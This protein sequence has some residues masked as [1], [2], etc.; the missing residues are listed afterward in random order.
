MAADGVTGCL[1][2]SLGAAAPVVERSRQRGAT[3]EGVLRGTLTLGYCDR[4]DVSQIV[5]GLKE[6][7]RDHSPLQA[8]AWHW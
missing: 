6:L 3:G 4:V 1:P 7:A 2:S 5:E 8:P